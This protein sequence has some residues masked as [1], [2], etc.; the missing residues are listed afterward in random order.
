MTVDELTALMN[1]VFDLD[2]RSN[3]DGTVSYTANTY[4]GTHVLTIKIEDVE[5]LI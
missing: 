3:A 2:F 5:A 1:R 4:S